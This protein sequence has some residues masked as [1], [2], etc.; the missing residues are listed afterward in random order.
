MLA[1]DIAYPPVLKPAQQEAKA[2]VLAAELLA[3]FHYKGMRQD[4]AFSASIFDRYLKSLDAEKL[5]F[6]ILQIRV[7]VKEALMSRFFRR[8][9]RRK[10]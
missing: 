3:R 4:E 9:K 10:Y 1:G 6:T 2:A 7:C 5:F 8:R